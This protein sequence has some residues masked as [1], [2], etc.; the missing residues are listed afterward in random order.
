M[1][2]RLQGVDMEELVIDDISLDES[3]GRVTISGV[4]DTPGVAAKVFDEIAD[5]GI[6]VDMIVQ[7]HD[8]QRKTRA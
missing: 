3:Q 6:F 1:V 4:P 8:G 7:S 5:A 2:T